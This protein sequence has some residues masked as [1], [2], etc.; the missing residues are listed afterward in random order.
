MTQNFTELID[1]LTATLDVGDQKETLLKLTEK[2][3]LSEADPD[4]LS[5]IDSLIKTDNEIKLFEDRHIINSGDPALTES[6]KVLKKNLVKMEVL[7]YKNT[8]D[9]FNLVKEVKTITDETRE[10]KALLPK[11]TNDILKV[12][13]NA[14]NDK[15]GSVNDILEK[16]NNK[17]NDLVEDL[18]KMK[19]VNSETNSD[20][21]KPEQVGG[22]NDNNNEYF[23]IKYIKYKKKYIYLKKNILN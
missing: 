8:I 19:T 15:V 14:L 22:F 13:I 10:Q 18:N 11:Q 12:F 6:F 1:K 3:D 2:L 17:N 21:Q 20:E 16:T 5:Q 4:L 23:L 9:K 7:L